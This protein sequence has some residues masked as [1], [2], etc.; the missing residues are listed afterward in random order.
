MAADGRFVVAFDR[1]TGPTSTLE[2]V[3]R[4]GRRALV[5][6]VM[7]RLFMDALDDPFA[8]VDRELEACPLGAAADAVLSRVVQPGPF[9]IPQLPVVT[10]AG[11]VADTLLALS[12]LQGA[13]V[14]GARSEPRD[15]G[16]GG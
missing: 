3:L 6:N 10:G 9:E 11:T 4:D 1:D 8:A 14:V 13:R 7:G 12:T 16:N 15:E 5:V 2:A